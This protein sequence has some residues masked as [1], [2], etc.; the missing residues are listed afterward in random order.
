MS[1]RRNWEPPTGT[2]GGGGTLACAVGKGGAG[3]VLI[4][5]TGEKA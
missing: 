2:K 3:G 4:P 1:P 5:T